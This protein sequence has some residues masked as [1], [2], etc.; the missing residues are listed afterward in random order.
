M[1]IGEAA[2]TTGI[3]AKMIRYYEETGLIRPALRTYSGY[4]VYS[5]RDRGTS[6]ALA[7]PRKS[8]RRRQGHRAGPRPGASAEAQ[9]VGR[10]DRHSGAFGSQLSWRRKTGLPHPANPGDS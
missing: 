8:Q 4:R 10:N 1:N 2:K 5:D 7:R 3:S 9:G 6:A